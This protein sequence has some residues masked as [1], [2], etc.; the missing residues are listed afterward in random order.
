MAVLTTLVNVPTVSSCPPDKWPATALDMDGFSATHN[1]LG[2]LDL[3]VLMQRRRCS[4][5]AQRRTDVKRV[6][7]LL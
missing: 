3:M 6:D 4:E 7:Q 5:V 2:I 1:I